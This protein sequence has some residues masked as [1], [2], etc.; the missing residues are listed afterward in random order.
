M[1]ES[2]FRRSV[3]HPD[4]WQAFRGVRSPAFSRDQQAERG[5]QRN[6]QFDEVKANLRSAGFDPMIMSPQESAAFLAGQAQKWPPVIKAAN[7][8]PRNKRRK[9]P[10]R[11]ISPRPPSDKGV[12]QRRANGFHASHNGQRDGRRDNGIFDGGGAA[13]T[14][15]KSAQH[16]HRRPLI[17]ALLVSLKPY[18]NGCRRRGHQAAPTPWHQDIEF[19]VCTWPAIYRQL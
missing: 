18:H 11:R 1:T 13:L 3:S 8:Q 14:L 6:P 15:Q 10:S 2:G 9:A 12:V 19:W 17:R 5:G 16:L 4:V 7:I